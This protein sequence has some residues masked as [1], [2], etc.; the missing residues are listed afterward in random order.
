L[1]NCVTGD[2]LVK[3]ARSL[4]R[5]AEKYDQAFSEIEPVGLTIAETARVL[6]ATGMALK[7]AAGHVELTMAESMTILTDGA[8]F[9]VG[10]GA[11]MSAVDGS[12]QVELGGQILVWIRSILVRTIDLLRSGR[13]T[14]PCEGTHGQNPTC[15]L[16]PVLARDLSMV[17]GWPSPGAAWSRRLRPGCWNGPQGSSGTTG[18]NSVPAV[19]P[20][21]SMRV[22]A[23]AVIE[24][25]FQRV[26]QA[27]AISQGRLVLERLLRRSC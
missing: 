6:A 8:D 17:G 9:I 23:Q 15:T 10:I 19:T 11:A 16:V 12:G 7:L 22:I 21:Q 2:F 25:A 1:D 24:L 4:A 5:H 18:L 20:G 27:H 14:C 26:S 3:F 13:W